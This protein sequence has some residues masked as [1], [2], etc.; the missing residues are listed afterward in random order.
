[1]GDRLD[2]V[3]D[4]GELQ[5]TRRLIRGSPLIAVAASAGV[6]SRRSSGRASRPIAAGELGGVP[7]DVRD[8]RALA[9]ERRADAAAPP[10]T[11]PR[12]GEAERRAPGP[13]RRRLVR[14]LGGAMPA[15]GSESVSDSITRA[16]A[17]PSAMQ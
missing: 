5:A 7:G 11:A 16:S 14:A 9:G 15:S 6:S 8:V 10:I 17:I 1:M 4:R 2:P 3:S 13:R 12:T